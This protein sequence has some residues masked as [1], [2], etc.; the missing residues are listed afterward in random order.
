MRSVKLGNILVLK[1]NFIGAPPPSITWM[2]NGTLIDPASNPDKTLNSDSGVG[3]NSTFSW[4]NTVLE[5]R[6]SYDC[7]AMNTYG[8]S[9]ATFDDV[10]ISGKLSHNLCLC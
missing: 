1:C 10:F 3:G 2:L 4:N 9:V 6:G 5:A 7:R 8:S